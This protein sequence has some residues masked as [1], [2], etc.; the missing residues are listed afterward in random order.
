MLEND[1]TLIQVCG[2]HMENIYLYCISHSKIQ[3]LTF[4]LLI[5]QAKIRGKNHK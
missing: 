3:E 4:I 1:L 2:H 5:G